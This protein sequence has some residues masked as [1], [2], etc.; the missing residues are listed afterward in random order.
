ME[1]TKRIELS[2]EPQ[3]TNTHNQHLPTF[4]PSQSGGAD[5][6]ESGKVIGHFLLVGLITALHP[7]LVQ[8]VV[9]AE[10]ELE[11]VPEEA[12]VEQL[13]LQPGIHTE[14]GAGLH[15]HTVQSREVLVCV[16]GGV[17]VCGVDKF[18]IK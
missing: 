11:D 17:G 18:W 15:R 3:P 12:G 13:G 10:H 1:S 4:Y 6:T 9:V 2:Y 14:D 5:D 7:S 16:C 8:S